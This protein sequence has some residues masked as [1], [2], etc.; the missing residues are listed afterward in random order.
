MKAIG[1]ATLT[2]VVSSFVLVRAAEPAATDD[3]V[4]MDFVA[5]SNGQIHALELLPDFGRSPA[6]RVGGAGAQPV[7]GR[8]YQRAKADMALPDSLVTTLGKAVRLGDLEVTPQKVERKRVVFKFPNAQFKPELSEHE[9]LVLHVQLKNVSKDTEFRATDLAFDHL[10][11]DGMHPA[12]TLPYTH[13]ESPSG[14]RFGGPFKW[15]PV[16]K[17]VANLAEGEFVE[18]QEDK[19]L[20]PGEQIKTLILTDP[21]DRVPEALKNEKDKLL[22]RVQF[23]RGLVVVK[24]RDVSTTGVIGVRF[25]VGQIEAKREDQQ[26]SP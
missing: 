17:P 7:F 4:L 20:K 3:A 5:K 14:K 1:T 10:W 23:R 21:G 18:G 26:R 15:N 11:K 19:V 2:L 9:A 16:K 12:A 8:S 22:W 24:D 25:E 6:K 13:L